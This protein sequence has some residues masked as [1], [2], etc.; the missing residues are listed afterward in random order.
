MKGS[1]EGQKREL[2]RVLD[3]SFFPKSVVIAILIFSLYF[4]CVWVCRGVDPNV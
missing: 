1:T 4:L 3:L 2:L